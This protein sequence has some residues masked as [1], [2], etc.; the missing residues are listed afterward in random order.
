MIKFGKLCRKN[1]YKVLDS[2]VNLDI[3]VIFIMTNLF[4]SFINNP[5]STIELISNTYYKKYR[6]L[7]DYNYTCHEWMNCTMITKFSC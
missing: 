2:R 6:G 3:S 1:R 4:H 5:I 7:V